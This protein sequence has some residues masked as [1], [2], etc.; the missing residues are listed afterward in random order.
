MSSNR[1]FVQFSLSSKKRVKGMQLENKF[2]SNT[3]V[4]GGSDKKNQLNLI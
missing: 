1:E 2:S 4:N 3:T